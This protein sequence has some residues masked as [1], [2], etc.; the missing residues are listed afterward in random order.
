M[1][2][3]FSCPECN[4][5]YRVK[6]ES[7]GMIGRC[8]CGAK[9]KIPTSSSGLFSTDRKITPNE[10]SAVPKKDQS[11]GSED[12]QNIQTIICPHCNKKYR[13]YAESISQEM[14]KVRCKA[15]GRTISLG[16]DVTRN[17]QRS[18]ERYTSEPSEVKEV[19]KR[20]ADVISQHN[21][22]TV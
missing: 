17:M 8:S 16:D 22:S 9:F 20:T 12:V 10:N 1:P 14:M 13:L 3:E 15:C 7:A 2:I 4:K 6:E 21:S 11:E 5:F 18:P 19:S